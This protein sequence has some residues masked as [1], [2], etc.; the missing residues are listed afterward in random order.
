MTF[1]FFQE[2]NAH[3][4]LYEGRLVGEPDSH[5]FGALR[6]GIFDGEIRTQNDG[7]YYVERAQKYFSDNSNETFHS[8]IYHEDHL[9]DPFHHSRH[10]ERPLFFLVNVNYV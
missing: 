7:V 2:H 10:G 5:A 4:H 8:V 3:K 6:D 9:K 1:F